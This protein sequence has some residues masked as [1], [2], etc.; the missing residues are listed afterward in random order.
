MIRRLKNTSRILLN[1]GLISSMR[2]RKMMNLCFWPSVRKKLKLE[3]FGLEIMILKILWFTREC[4]LDIRNSL[5]RNSFSFQ[6]KI[7]LVQ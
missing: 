1:I 7:T 3:K 6:F 4:Q 2:I 5:I